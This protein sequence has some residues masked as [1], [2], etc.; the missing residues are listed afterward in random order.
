M[1]GMRDSLTVEDYG[2]RVGFLAIDNDLAGFYGLFLVIVNIFKNHCKLERVL[3]DARNIPAA[4]P[5]IRSR[6]YLAV[7]SLATFPCSMC[8]M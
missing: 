8:C 2:R 3:T 4:Y 5:E 6:R 1:E 7:S